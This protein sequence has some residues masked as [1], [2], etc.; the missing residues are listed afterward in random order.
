MPPFQGMSQQGGV[1]NVVGT[2]PVVRNFQS[3]ES[4][5][6]EYPASI[7]GV[8]KDS[9]GAALGSCLVTLFRTADNSLVHQVISDVNG[10][11]RIYASLVLQHYIL[12][13]KV[14]SPDVT[15]ATVN[16]LTGA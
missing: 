15:G 7:V 6:F 1:P 12:A 2:L 14:G 8:T 10:N 13:Y 5:V 9:A 11:Y 16:T 3:G 4:P